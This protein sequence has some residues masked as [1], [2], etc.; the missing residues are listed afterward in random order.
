[1]TVWAFLSILVGSLGAVT[2]A[3]LQFTRRLTDEDDTCP[4]LQEWDHSTG[5]KKGQPSGTVTRCTLPD[6]HKGPHHCMHP[7]AREDYWWPNY[8]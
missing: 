1:M 5:K 2:V 8:E 4:A 6:G 7:S 3:A